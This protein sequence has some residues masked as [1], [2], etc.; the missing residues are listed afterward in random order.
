MLTQRMLDVQEI[1]NRT[2]QTNHPLII[3]PPLSSTH[4]DTV[5]SF[6]TM[7]YGFIYHKPLSGPWELWVPF[8]LYCALLPP[9]L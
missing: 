2:N 1:K 5:F 3:K 6:L 7:G 8:P 9:M 4:S